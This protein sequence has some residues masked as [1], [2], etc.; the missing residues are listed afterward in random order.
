MPN[1]NLYQY[2]RAERYPLSEQQQCQTLLK[3]PFMQQAKQAR[4]ERYQN[5]WTPVYHFVN[6]E[7]Y[8]NDPNGFCYWNGR[9]HLF[10]Q[11]LVERYMVW[12]HAV[13][14]DLVHWT[15]LPYAIYP[16]PSE[17]EESSWSG[18]ACTTDSCA[19]ILYYGHGA[20]TG[21]YCQTSND[22]LLLNWE[23]T[24]HGPAVAGDCSL[25]EWRRVPYA[26]Y[27]AL[28]DGTLFFDQGKYWGICGGVQ[29]RADD[30]FTRQEYLFSSTDLKEWHYEHPFLV[31]DTFNANGDDGAC[32][33]IVPFGPDADGRLLLT[34]SH[35]NGPEYLIGRLDRTKMRLHAVGGEQLSPATLFGGYMAPAACADPTG[36]GVPTAVYVMHCVGF[37]ACMSL[38]H[39]LYP[40]QDKQ[41]IRVEVAQQIETLRRNER[42]VSPFTVQAGQEVVVDAARGTAVEIDL[43]LEFHPDATPTLKLFRSGDGKYYTALSLFTNRGEQFRPDEDWKVDCVMLLDATNACDDTAALRATATECLTVPQNYGQPIKLRIFLDQSVIEVFTETGRSLGR[44]VLPPEHADTFSITARNYAVSVREMTVWDMEPIGQAFSDAERL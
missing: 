22:P 26:E 42:V 20:H 17:N 10:F 7:G 23:R 2:R 1:F 4:A 31:D 35:R 24:T 30:T 19:S 32:P 40:A 41:R 14:R 21:L 5:R 38:P 25:P 27:P 36:N 9:Y 3:D 28:Y 11:Q 15:E 12:G 29:R 33:Y 34:F 18:G 13:S 43:T 8:M 39:K 37:D 44:R 6:A 16:D